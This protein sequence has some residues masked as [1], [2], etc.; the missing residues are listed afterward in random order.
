MKFMRV[1]GL[2]SIRQKGNY[3][4]D[5]F[6]SAPARKGIYAFIW[7]YYEPFLALW[8]DRNV[9]EYKN[10]GI[11]TFEYTGM[12]WTHYIDLA[13]SSNIVGSWVK[14]HTSE[15]ETIVRKQKALLNGELLGD[16]F[17]CFRG[18]PPRCNPHVAFSKDLMEVFIE[19]V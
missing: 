10:N 4:R 13:K 17:D 8:S 15:L 16:V 5:T 1:G 6:H 19:K 18:Y 7:P 12:V 3:G 11:R 2:S 9:A 14:V